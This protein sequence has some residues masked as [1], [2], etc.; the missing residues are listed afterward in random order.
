MELLGT[1]PEL[2]PMAKAIGR[3]RTELY[4]RIVPSSRLL[5]RELLR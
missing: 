1:V 3:E 2:F 4:L 5:R